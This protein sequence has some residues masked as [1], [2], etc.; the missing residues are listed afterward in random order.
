MS[1]RQQSE[2]SELVAA[3]AAIEEELRK[4]ESLAQEVRTGPLRAQKHLEK[5]GHLLNS[6]ADCDE[7]LVAHMRSLLGVLNGWRSASRPWPPR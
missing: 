2:S 7:R 6:V 4:F 1:K 5:M 3:A